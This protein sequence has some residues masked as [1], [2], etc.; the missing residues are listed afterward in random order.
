MIE[1]LTVQ[2]YAED[3]RDV[4]RVTLSAYKINFIGASVD[5]VVINGLSVRPVEIWF[6]EGSMLSLIVS[7]SDL[8]LLEKAVGSFR[9]GID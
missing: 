2:H 1:T 3:I 4:K 5:D 6:E 7:H 9:L 8:D